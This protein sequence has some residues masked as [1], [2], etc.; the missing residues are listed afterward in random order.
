MENRLRYDAN[1]IIARLFFQ[2]K[3]MN[4]WSIPPLKKIFPA[5]IAQYLESIALNMDTVCSAN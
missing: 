5:R 3:D 2:K 4:I 1:Y